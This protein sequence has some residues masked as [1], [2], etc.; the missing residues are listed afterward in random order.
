M[1]KYLAVQAERF[2]NPVL[3]IFHTELGSGLR[4]KKRTLDNDGRKVSETLGFPIFF[5]KHNYGLQTTIGT[6]EHLKILRY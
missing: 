1:D 3:R 6:V 4:R 2:R 5:Q